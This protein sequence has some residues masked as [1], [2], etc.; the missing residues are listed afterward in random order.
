MSQCFEEIGEVVSVINEK[1]VKISLKR[2]SSCDKCGVCGMGTKPEITFLAENTIGAKP[3]DR[4]V[5]KMETGTLFK[6]A[7]LVYTL[8]LIM[9]IVGFLFGDLG[10]RFIGLNTSTSENI[11]ILTGFILLGSTYYYIRRLDRRTN[12]TKNFQPRLIKIID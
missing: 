7:F 10:A 11:G 3:G 4:I 8:P 12:F 5:L 1:I 9:L 2:H 6:A